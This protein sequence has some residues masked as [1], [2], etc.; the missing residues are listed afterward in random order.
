[1]SLDYRLHPYLWNYSPQGKQLEAAQEIHSILS[2]H[3]TNQA[4][5]LPT[6]DRMLA[7]HFVDVLGTC[8]NKGTDFDLLVSATRFAAATTPYLLADDAAPLWTNRVWSK[9]LAT[10]ALASRYFSF[11][12]AAARRD[13]AATVDIGKQLMEHHGELLSSTAYSEVLEY[14]IGSMQTAAYAMENL[15]L[16]VS[17]EEKYGRNMRTDFPRLFVVALARQGRAFR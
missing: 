10:N 5:K 3:N 12:A 4:G 9:C 8:S 2:G 6:I 14:T 13:H 15:E 1:M 16:V 7:M 11:L 17:L